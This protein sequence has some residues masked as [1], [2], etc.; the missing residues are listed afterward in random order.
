MT[1]QTPFD[2]H[3]SY[4]ALPEHFHGYAEPTP[5]A[6]PKLIQFNKELAESLGINI[7]QLEAENPTLI[8]SGNKLPEGAD[9]IA[10][11]YSGH[12]FGNL[13]PNMGDGRAILLGEVIAADQHHYGVQLKGAGP[14]PFSRRGDGR[15]AIGPVLREY[16]HSE[17]MHILGVPTTRALAAVSTGQPIYREIQHPGAIIT[18]TARSFVRV[19]TFQHF[20]IRGDYDGLKTLADY[21]IEH[22]YPELKGV[23]TPYLD[24]LNAVIDRQAKLIAQWMQ[25]GF[26]HGVMNTDNMSIS[27]DTIDYGPCAFMDQYHPETVFSSIDRRGRY[28]YRNQPAAGHWDL[29]RLAEAMAQLLSEDHDEAGALAQEAIN[30][31]PAKYEAYWLAGFCQKIGI[32]TPINGDKA[33]VEDLLEAMAASNADFTLTFYH[34]SNALADSTANDQVIRDLFD[35]PKDFEAWAEQ[36]RDRLVTEFPSDEERQAQMRKVNPLYIA[37]NHLVEAVVKAAEENEDY[38]PFY[39][40]LEVLKQPFTEQAGKEA[41]ARPAHADEVVLR[42][43]CGT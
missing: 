22:T 16:I 36:W 23:E 1:D 42:T 43:F 2:F 37:R 30:G 17:A 35:N 11:A 26:I 8:F 21:V 40:L 33:L 20:A 15:A 38:Q 28:A 29:C 41:Y 4:E 34:L 10:M 13:N 7:E 31:Y 18:R 39:D 3:N 5:V 14:T 12:Q 32:S 6:D 27:G 25:L 24:L 19:G 9:P